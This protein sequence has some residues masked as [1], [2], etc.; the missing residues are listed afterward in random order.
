[1]KTIMKLQSIGVFALLG[2]LALSGPA[3]ASLRKAG[4]WP[5][6]EKKVSLDVKHVSVDE[7]LEQLA[8]KA[9]WSLVIPEPLGGTVTLHVR[10]ERADRVL[11]AIFAEGDIVATRDG[12]ILRV[13]KGAAVNGKGVE[14]KGDAAEGVDAAEA[15]APRTDRVDETKPKAPEPA[16]AASAT[17][18]DGQGSDRMVKGQSLRIEKGET[19]HD[20]SVFGGSVDVYGKVTGDLVVTGGA[21]R[22]HAGA[23]I[24]GDATA[25][26]GSMHVEDDAR[27]EGDVGVVGGVLTRGERSIIKGDVSRSDKP[28]KGIKVS[29]DHEDPPKP[30]L[31]RARDGIGHALSSFATLFVLGIVFLAL[32][33][34][35][36]EMLRLEVATRPVRN[37]ALGIVGLLGFVTAFAVLCVTVIGIPVALV[38]LCLGILAALAGVVSVAQVGGELLLR[39]RTENPYAHLALG[40]FLLVALGSIPVI[41]GFLWSVVSFIG[42]GT[43]V[44]TRVAGFM[45][46]KGAATEVPAQGPYRSDV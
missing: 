4:T 8:D 34:R 21:A 7:A 14:P 6:E 15:P 10:D 36:M 42:I 13:A 2:T 40:C 11:E 38:G 24:K 37:F 30:F 25:I 26:G 22:I 23:V 29:V 44:A 32:T 17:D 16:A 18:G 9:G 39:H 45:A 5:K 12:G 35:R 43:L 1:M 3:E 46:K 31:H 20:V 19:V 33:G 41:G 27:I 28:E